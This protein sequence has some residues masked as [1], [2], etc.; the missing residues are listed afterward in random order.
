MNSYLLGVKIS[1]ELKVKLEAEALKMGLTT[2][3]YVRYLLIKTHN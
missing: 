3:S 1:P 2:S